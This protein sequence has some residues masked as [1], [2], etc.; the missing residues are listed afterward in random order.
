[1][2][3][4]QLKELQMNNAL[5]LLEKEVW[6]ISG[7]NDISCSQTI[8]C[9]VCSCHAECTIA[10]DLKDNIVIEYVKEN[11]AELMI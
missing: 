1:M 9:E 8:N 3:G 5:Y 6:Y 2:S 7:P 11:R 4:L 10:I